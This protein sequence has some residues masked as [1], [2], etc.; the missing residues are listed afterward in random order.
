MQNPELFPKMPYL[1]RIDVLRQTM[2]LLLL[3][4]LHRLSESAGNLFRKL[5]N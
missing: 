1:I 4:L 2:F 5:Y 3:P